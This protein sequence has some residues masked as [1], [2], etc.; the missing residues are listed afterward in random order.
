MKVTKATPVK[1][2]KVTSKEKSR[3]ITEKIIPKHAPK[4]K[5]GARKSSG[6]LGCG[7]FQKQSQAPHKI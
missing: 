3:S 7:T 2:S 6:S 1:S 5:A 4:P